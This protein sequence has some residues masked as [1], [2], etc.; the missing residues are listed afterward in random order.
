M[1]AEAPVSG[2]QRISRQ[3]VLVACVAVA[4]LVV[5]ALVGAALLGRQAVDADADLE[6][7]PTSAVV[8][9]QRA[10]PSGDASSDSGSRVQCWDGGIRASH[11]ECAP[12]RGVA[13][14]KWLFPGLARDFNRCNDAAAYDGKVR[15]FGCTVL[16]GDQTARVV[17]SEWQTFKLGD[18]HYRRKYGSPDRTGPQFNIWGAV[19]VSNTYQTSRMFTSGLPYSVTVASKSQAAATSV[20]ERLRYQPADATLPYR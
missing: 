6:V 8:P 15:A 14:M 11:T 7:S 13:A 3:G 5:V 1:P 10:A 18:D 9:T 4:L 2:D 19:W 16:Y 12:P 20:M 17:Y